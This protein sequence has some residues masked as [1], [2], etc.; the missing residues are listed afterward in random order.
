MYI[1]C[2][3]ICVCLLCIKEGEKFF[4]C[5]ANEFYENRNNEQGV[6]LQRLQLCMEQKVPIEFYMASY[7]SGEKSR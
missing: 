4:G 7:T 5:S 6:S 2:S 1:I 3:Q